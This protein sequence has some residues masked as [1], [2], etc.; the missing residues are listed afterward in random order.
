M[1]PGALRGGDEDD[2]AADD[3]GTGRRDVGL[4]AE[5]DARGFDDAE[6]LPGGR[7]VTSGSVGLSGA[8]AEVAGL[9]FQ[10]DL[11]E[12]AGGGGDAGDAGGLA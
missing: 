7:K 8:G 3:V 5:G 10:E 12:G 4:W 9:D 6:G 2:V 11:D 1:E